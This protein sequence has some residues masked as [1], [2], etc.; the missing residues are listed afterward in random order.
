MR[1]STVDALVAAGLDPTEVSRVIR[2]ALEEDLGP[3]GIDVTSR[4]T[5]PADQTD[6]AELVARGDGIVAGLIV[7]AAVFELIDQR[8]VVEPRIA[9]GTRVTRGTPLATVTGPTPSCVPLR[10]HPS[11]G[12]MDRR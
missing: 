3:D 1:P 6:T 4:A 5:I 12:S 10:V 11:G 2:V 7:A 8:V 9:D